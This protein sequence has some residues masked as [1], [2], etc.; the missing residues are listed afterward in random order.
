MPVDGTAASQ[1]E[2]T[3]RAQIELDGGLIDGPLALANASPGRGE[4]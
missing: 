1:D 2:H 4:D 3:Q